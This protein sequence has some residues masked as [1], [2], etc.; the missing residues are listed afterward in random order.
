MSIRVSEVREEEEASSS[1]NQPNKITNRS[2]EKHLLPIS[3]SKWTREEISSDDQP[4]KR[5]RP[6]LRR[7]KCDACKRNLSQLSNLITHQ[8]IHTGERPY[9]CEICQD[10]FIQ[11]SSLNS[12]RRTHIKEPIY[13]IKSSKQTQKI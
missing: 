8:R 12:H 5:K 7:Y 1:N 6:N 13:S 11:L 3:N 2:K 10:R 4:N 9:V